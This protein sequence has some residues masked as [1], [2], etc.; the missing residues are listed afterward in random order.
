V[1]KIIKTVP[2]YAGFEPYEISWV[3][4]AAK[5][6]PGLERDDHRI[7][8]NWSGSRAVGYDLEPKSVKAS[9]EFFM[10]KE[11]HKDKAGH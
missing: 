10:H 9:V 4:F 11:V 7:G 3:D 5:W 1:E 2:A 8:V 6:I